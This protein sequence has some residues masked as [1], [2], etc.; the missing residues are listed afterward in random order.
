LLNA[1]NRARVSGSSPLAQPALQ[2]RNRVL[3]RF[4]YADASRPAIVEGFTRKTFAAMGD[5]VREQAVAAGLMSAADF[6]RGIADLYRMAE[7]DGVF[8]YTFFKAIGF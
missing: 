5:E 1:N 6:A 3:P 4:D 8:C 7:S 2:I